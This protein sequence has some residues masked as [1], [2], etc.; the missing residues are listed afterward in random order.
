VH[1][2][3]RII[4]LQQFIYQH[5]FFPIINP[6]F[7]SLMYAIAFVLVCFLPVLLLYRKKIFIK[8]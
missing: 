1:D 8:I 2:G 7:G 3:A 6:S 4:D 5:W